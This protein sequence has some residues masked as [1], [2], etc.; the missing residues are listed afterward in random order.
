MTIRL[1]NGAE[2]ECIVCFVTE[3]Y[4]TI[5]FEGWLDIRNLVE[6]FTEDGCF[7]IV[8]IESGSE[9][10][11]IGYTNLVEIRQDRN[12]EETLLYLKKE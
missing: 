2:F 10:E 7:K 4:M 8:R 6:M 12:I 5:R 1:N 3:M 9:K 11:F